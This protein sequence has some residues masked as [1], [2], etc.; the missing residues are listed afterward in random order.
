MGLISRVSSRTYRQKSMAS[1]G[2]VEEGDVIRAPTEE[3]LSSFLSAVKSHKQF[4]SSWRLDN[5]YLDRFLYCAKNDEGKAL[6]RYLKYQNTISKLANLKRVLSGDL[7]FIMPSIKAF[8]EMECLSFYGFDKEGHGIIAYNCEKFDVS[9]PYC[10]EALVLTFLAEF[11]YLME[12]YP[13]IRKNGC[14]FIE[15]HSAMN[16]S[17]YK[18]FVTSAKDMGALMDLFQGALPVKLKTI[19]I[20]NE[21]SFFSV[22]WKIFKPFLSKKMLSRLHIQGKDH[23]P[24]VE[25]LGGVE[26][27]PGFLA[28]GESKVLQ[29][30]DDWDLET[31]LR[32]AL[33]FETS[34]TAQL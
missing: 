18:L 4:Q 25:A 12:K 10:V 26:N 34:D 27:T 23:A 13:D 32:K 22:I 24:M 2:Y 33:P 16:W 20:L 21:A 14:I 5:D 11:D 29:F 7:E 17:H 30:G 1:D 3:E 28:V 19:W 15:D 6:E 31:Y 9:I 8:R